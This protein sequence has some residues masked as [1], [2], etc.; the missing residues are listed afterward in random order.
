MDTDTGD[1]S[2]ATWSIAVPLTYAVTGRAGKTVR[3]AT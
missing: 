3:M 2:L 1:V